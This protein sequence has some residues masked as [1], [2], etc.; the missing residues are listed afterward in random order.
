MLAA[1]FLKANALLCGILA[2]AITRVKKIVSLRPSVWDISSRKHPGLF[3]ITSRMWGSR[4]RLEWKPAREPM[5][6]GALHAQL[7]AG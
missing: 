2:A 7:S 3:M 4:P 6:L 5:I 1:G